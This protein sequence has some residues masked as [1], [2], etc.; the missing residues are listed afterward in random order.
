MKFVIPRAKLMAVRR[1]ARAAFPNEYLSVLW[2]QRTGSDVRI[3]EFRSIPFHGTPDA[4]SYDQLAITRSKRAALRVG[5]EFVG[6]IHSHVWDKQDAFTCEHL[7]PDDQR[8]S[9][10]NGELL[11]GII[12]VYN[13]GRSTEVHWYEPQVPPEVTYV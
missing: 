4:A 2:G 3:E 10:I 7:S 13:Q 9:A 1:Q 6:T 11:S 8:T 5:L 12:Y